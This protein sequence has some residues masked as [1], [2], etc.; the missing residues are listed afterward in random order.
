MRW[1][2]IFRYRKIHWLGIFALACALALDWFSYKSDA[3]TTER[4]SGLVGMFMLWAVFVGAF[5]LLQRFS[6]GRFRGSVGT[7][8]FEFTADGL[9]ESHA[10]G[11]TELRVAGIRHVGE[12]ASHFFIL[13]KTGSG[14]V[15]PKRDLQS[16]DAIHE[17]QKRV[18]ASG[19]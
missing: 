13:S 14:I 18:A 4:I 11:K 3:T 10:N 9:T 8:A 17:L 2:V 5:L 6:G 19:A 16:Y 1:Y 7:H 15:I 12:T